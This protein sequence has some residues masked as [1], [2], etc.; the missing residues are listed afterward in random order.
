[1]TLVQE[2]QSRLNVREDILMG[3][4]STSMVGGRGGGNWTQLCLLKDQ[5]AL[6]FR[7]RVEVRGWK[8]TQE[9]AEVRGILVRP[10]Q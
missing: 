8:V 5:W 10:T 7:K 3:V 2:W 6:T 4:G 9:T 1:M